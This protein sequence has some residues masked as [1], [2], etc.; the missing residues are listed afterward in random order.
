MVQKELSLL[1]LI[2]LFLALGM[3]FGAWIDHPMTH[4]K[5]LSSS[6]FGIWHPLFITFVAYVFILV[7]RVLIHF[8]K[9]IKD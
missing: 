2:F 1:I 4:I 3:H 8:V 6:S 9:R 5:S 7:I